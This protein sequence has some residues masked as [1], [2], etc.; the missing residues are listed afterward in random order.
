MDDEQMTRAARISDRIVVFV[1]IAGVNQATRIDVQAIMKRVE[2]NPQGGLEVWLGHGER[3][4]GRS[5][6]VYEQGM[7]LGL[8]PV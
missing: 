2:M 7:S 4:D 5:S 3:H 8:H 6:Y 1:F